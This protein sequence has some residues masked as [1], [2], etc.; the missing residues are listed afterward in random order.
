M[1]IIWGGLETGSHSQRFW[2][3]CSGMWMGCWD[4][5]RGPQAALM[6]CR[7]WEPLPPSSGYLRF[8][9]FSLCNVK[10]LYCKNCLRPQSVYQEKGKCVSMYKQ[11]VADMFIFHLHYNLSMETI[12]NILQAIGKVRDESEMRIWSTCLH[13]RPADQ[14]TRPYKLSHYWLS[15]FPQVHYLLCWLSF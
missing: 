4:S 5:P 15:Q 6:C 3:G 1:G 12:K 14:S 7:V 2:L 9:F 8:F 10:T 13:S 11:Y